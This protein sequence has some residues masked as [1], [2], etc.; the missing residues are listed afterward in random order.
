MTATQ[1]RAA[2]R[3]YGYPPWRD[4]SGRFSALKALVFALLPLPALIQAIAWATQGLTGHPSQTVLLLT[5]FWSDRLL[6]ATLAVTPLAA[7]FALPRLT[8]VRR[9]L[10][11]AAAAYAA[12]HL[13]VY[14]FQQGFAW[15]FIVVQMASHPV[16]TI[17]LASLLGL[18]ALAF[19]ST[20]AWVRRLGRAWKRLHLLAHP[21][22]ILALLHSF[23][24]APSD[25]TLSATYAGFYL[26]LLAWRLLPKGARRHPA[27]LL[28]LALA[29]AAGTAGLEAGWYALATGL[30]WP[31]I[32]AANLSLA[33]GIRPAQWVALGGLAI[34]AAM[35]VRWAGP[36][37]MTRL[38]ASA[39]SL[40]ARETER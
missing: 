23:M 4:R 31:R 30:P 6:V 1:G 37:M 11:V 26:W 35:A 29:A 15:G 21:A 20:D 17:G 38:F 18:A 28:A 39:I 7:L 19:T 22:T 34:A 9:M 25:V 2:R 8:L 24:E 27:A 3:A 32:L 5:G 16:L 36:R 33:A 14:A 13:G 10:G 12:A 40:P